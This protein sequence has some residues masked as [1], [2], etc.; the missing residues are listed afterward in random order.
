MLNGICLSVLGLDSLMLLGLTVKAIKEEKE[1][2]NHKRIIRAKM[3][4]EESVE[5]LKYLDLLMSDK[6]VIPA[7][8]F[9][10]E[11]ESFI[12][13]KGVYVLHNIDT[14]KYYV[15]RSERIIESVKNHFVG[16][17]ND[18]IYNGWKMG[19]TFTV[20]C[21]SLD[22]SEYLNLKKLQYEYIVKYDAENLNEETD[23]EEDIREVS[24]CIFEQ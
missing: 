19:N 12:D 23:F 21:M 4:Y 3:S 22:K 6:I 5:K 10:S 11:V 17:K 15:G 18:E 20:R 13:Y 1:R 9:I 16:I 14:N 24:D 7:S 8:V 2:E